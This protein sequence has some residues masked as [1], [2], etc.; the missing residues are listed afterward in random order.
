MRTLVKN[1]VPVGQ[2]INP[3]DMAKYI[4]LP[5]QLRKTEEAIDNGALKMEFTDSFA[6][7]FSASVAQAIATGLRTR[8][9][10][11]LSKTG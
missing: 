6:D 2:Y 9:D 11:H 5:A 1:K 10:I 4:A 7:Y 3:D 8:Q